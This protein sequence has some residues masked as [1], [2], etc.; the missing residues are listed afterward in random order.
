M[1]SQNNNFLPTAPGVS[2]PVETQTVAA[3]GTTMERGGESFPDDFEELISRYLT[4]KLREA[5]KHDKAG[6]FSCIT[7]EARG[8]RDSVLIIDAR[9][10][11]S[12][13]GIVPAN[14]A[15]ISEALADY[16]EKL[17]GQNPE[18][19]AKA[20]RIAELKAEL[21]SLEGKEAR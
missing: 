19:A 6:A 13:P 16:V 8:F 14:A 18:D 1:I 17:Q 9:A 15:T 7:I 10:Y 3:G 12:T 20:G 2:T 5:S 11:T 4:S 21:A